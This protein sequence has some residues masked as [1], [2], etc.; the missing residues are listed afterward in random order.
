MQCVFTSGTDVPRARTISKSPK[1]SENSG[2]FSSLFSSFSGIA[3]PQ[4]VVTQVSKV[5]NE[6]SDPM[7]TR[8][9]GITLSIFSADINVRLDKKITTELYR[10]TKKTPPS[11]M[12]YELIYVSQS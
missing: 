12:K 1:P 3:T 5:V 7:K 2:F 9:L 6:A 8:E 10:S 11:K 4:P